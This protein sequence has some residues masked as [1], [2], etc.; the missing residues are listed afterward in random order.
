MFQKNRL[1]QTNPNFRW[2]LMNHLSHLNL[3]Y[4][5]YHW[6]PKYPQQPGT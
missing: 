4:Q 3:M 5:N 1:F 2:F 6:F